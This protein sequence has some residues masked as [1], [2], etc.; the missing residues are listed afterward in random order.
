MREAVTGVP[1]LRRSTHLL[2]DLHHPL[3]QEY[4]LATSSTNSV[5]HPWD[6]GGRITAVGY[7]VWRF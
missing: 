6:Y 3:P 4:I 7:E 2:H 1:T 5:Q